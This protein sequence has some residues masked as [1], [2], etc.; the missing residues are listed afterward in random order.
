[1]QLDK[2]ISFIFHRINEKPFRLSTIQLVEHQ[3]MNSKDYS[4]N[5][6]PIGGFFS[7][8]VCK[9]YKALFTLSMC[10]NHAISV[11]LL[12]YVFSERFGSQHC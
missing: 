6:N 2:Y 5:P 7:F 4:S 11:I 12:L 1:M 8:S 9:M 3:T 10:W